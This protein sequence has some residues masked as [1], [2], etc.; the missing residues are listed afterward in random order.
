[1]DNLQFKKVIQECITKYGFK[2]YRENF[3]YELDNVIIVINLQKSNFDNSYYINYGFCMKDIHDGLQYPKCNAKECDITCRFVDTTNKGNYQLDTLDSEKLI[4]SVEKNIDDF[5]MPVINE[6]IYK[7]FE[8]YP[9][10]ICLITLRL[11][12]YLGI[13]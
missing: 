12:E 3:Y 11:K 7:F 8:L 2:Y 1:M 6:G 9:N 4:M 10:Y 13:S 5:I